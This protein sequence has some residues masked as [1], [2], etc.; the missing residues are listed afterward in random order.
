MYSQ[1]TCKLYEIGSKEI[2]LTHSFT[3]DVAGVSEG[4]RDLPAE[5]AAKGKPGRSD[6][7]SWRDGGPERTAEGAQC[8]AEGAGG[9]HAGPERLLQHQE[10]GAGEV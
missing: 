6:P 2:P 8:P 7:A 4:R 10:P 1:P 5:A 3:L 9:D